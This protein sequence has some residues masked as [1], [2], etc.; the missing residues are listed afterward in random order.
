[1]T[2]QKK[3]AAAKAP[4][5]FERPAG[6]GS[7]RR[8]PKTG[9]VEQIAGTEPA[10]IGVPAEPVE[11]VDDDAQDTGDQGGGDQSGGD[12]LD[13]NVNDNAGAG[14]GEQES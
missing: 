11:P 6:G 14:A 10:P 5:V 7:F 2:R 1:M 13:T 4:V 12:G 8:N 3:G 9:E